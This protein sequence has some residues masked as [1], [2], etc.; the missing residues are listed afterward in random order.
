MT[1]TESRLPS[2]DLAVGRNAESMRWIDSAAFSEAKDPLLALRDAFGEF[3]NKMAE[4]ENL[5]SKHVYHNPNYT[6]FDAR[7]H[8]Q[9]LHYLMFKAEDL[10]LRF[11]LL[12]RPEE[13]AAY[14]SALDEQAQR[15]QKVFQEWHGEPE[16]DPEIPASFKEAMREMAAGQLTDMEKD[17][18]ATDAAGTDV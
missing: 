4:A 10:A 1:L 9:V 18:F 3:T 16:N 8:R 13:T 12:K 15:L 14:V 17:L 6:P 2:S 11:L 5:A 7:Q